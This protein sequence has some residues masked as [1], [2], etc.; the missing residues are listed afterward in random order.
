[1]ILRIGDAVPQGPPLH[2]TT[3]PRDAGQAVALLRH[4]RALSN[5]AA[6]FLALQ[7]CGNL[8]EAVVSN[9]A[10]ITDPQV[11]GLVSALAPGSPLYYYL[12]WAPLGVVLVAVLAVRLRRATAPRWVVRRVQ[13]ALAALAV[14]VAVKVVLITT[15]NPRFRDP[16]AA[17]ESVRSAAVTWA[18]GN[19]VAVVAV[20]AALVL[21]LSWRARLLDTAAG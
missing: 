7:L 13:A 18:Y 4:T 15:V 6:A 21:L 1:L 10:N 14:A 16:G 2:R 8:Y 11:G 9:P 20:A 19:G 17:V 5:T 12:P 3:L